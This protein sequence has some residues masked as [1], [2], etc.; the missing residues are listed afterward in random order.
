MPHALDPLPY[1]FDALEP[2][3]DARTLEIHHDK[4]HAAY[5]NNLNKALEAYPSSRSSAGRA[6]LA[7]RPGPGGDPHDRAEQRR[8][9]FAHNLYWRT[10]KRA[11]A[12]SLPGSWRKRSRL[13]SGRSPTSGRSSPSGGLAV[14]F[15]L[16]LAL[17]QD[18]RCT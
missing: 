15:G 14:R 7:S 13:R 8:G 16:G 4:H 5:V 1:P 18:G 10:M 2:V 9:H 11:A 17:R 12:A 6:D 3:L